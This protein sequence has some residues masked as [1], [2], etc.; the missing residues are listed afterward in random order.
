MEKFLSNMA[1]LFIVALIIF[2]VL[3]RLGATVLVMLSLVLLVA[4]LYSHYNLFSSEYRYSTWQER[5]KWY[6]PV[7]M[8][9]GI[10]VGV[11]FILSGLYNG[12]LSVPLLPTTNLSSGSSNAVT[13]TINNTAKAANTVINNAV[14][15]VTNTL[16]INTPKNNRPSN[17]LSNLGGLLNTPQKNNNLNR[18]NNY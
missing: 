13:A 8:Y 11:L 4:S 12:T 7:V 9:S 16:G 10:A 18:R 5:L 2:L 14:S 17:T 3:P 6:A 1:I 15:A